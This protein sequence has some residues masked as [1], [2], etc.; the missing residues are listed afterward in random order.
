MLGRC[1]VHNIKDVV[2]RILYLLEGRLEMIQVSVWC[3]HPQ[4]PMFAEERK[5]LHQHHFRFNFNVSSIIYKNASHFFY[6]ESCHSLLPTFYKRH[7]AHTQQSAAL[8]HYPNLSGVAPRRYH[9]N[10]PRHDARTY[11]RVRTQAFFLLHV[12]MCKRTNYAWEYLQRKSWRR[13]GQL[14]HVMRAA[15]VVEVVL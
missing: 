1:V 5:D 3:C 12:H 2:F 11:P 8:C 13:R 6:C 14:Y 15:T 10:F 9:S 7:P 4:G